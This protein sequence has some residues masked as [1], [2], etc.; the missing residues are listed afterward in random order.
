MCPVITATIKE[1]GRFTNEQQQFMS[2]PMYDL[3]FDVS[4]NACELYPVVNRCAVT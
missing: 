1:S 2:E 4:L 3:M